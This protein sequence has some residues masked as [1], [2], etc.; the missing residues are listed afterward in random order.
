LNKD[1]GFERAF[2]TPLPA[3]AT[4]VTD[5]AP[6]TYDERVNRILKAATETIAS[7]GYERAT[8]RAVARAAGVSLAGLYHYFPSKERMLFLIQY[9]TFNG[10]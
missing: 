8:M 9:R 10:L 3:S 1:T 7:V 4:P 6:A 5:R 2:D